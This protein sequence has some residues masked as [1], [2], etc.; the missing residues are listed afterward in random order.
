MVCNEGFASGN[1]GTY[2]EVDG[3]RAFAMNVT[4]GAL[5]APIVKKFFPDHP[6]QPTSS[7]LTLALPS[8]ACKFDESGS[9][10]VACAGD[11]IVSTATV[12]YYKS[13]DE[14]TI[15]RGISATTIKLELT[16]QGNDKLALEVSFDATVRGKKLK[17]SFAQTFGSLQSR[18]EAG[19][20]A[21]PSAG[22]AIMAGV[23]AANLQ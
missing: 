10:V 19:T 20:T 9:K 5:D 8:N 6:A 21:G 3:Y 14:I 4:I 7:S 2:L 15:R 13:P 17:Y 16:K 22:C 11:G 1:R 12:T 23:N 18:L